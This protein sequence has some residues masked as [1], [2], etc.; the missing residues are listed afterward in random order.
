MWNVPANERLLLSQTVSIIYI[1]GIL[2]IYL[3]DLKVK[4]VTD[5]R[6]GTEY[7]SS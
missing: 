6:F 1:F 2:S 4:E 7:L 5:V 3:H